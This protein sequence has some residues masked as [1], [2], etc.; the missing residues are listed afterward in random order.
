MP[1]PY[2]L[3]LAA[4]L[5]A[6][7][8]CAGPSAPAPPD[9]LAPTRA[10]ATSVRPAAPTAVPPTPSALAPAP[11]N[12]PTALAATAAALAGAPGALVAPT[13]TPLFPT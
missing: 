9:A 12:T 13:A 4:L 8:A 3:P 7:V 5:C 10:A 1:R 2:L 11:P 6:L